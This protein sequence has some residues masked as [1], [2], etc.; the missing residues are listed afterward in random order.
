MGPITPALVPL[1]SGGFQAPGVEDFKLPPIFG[2][3]SWLQ[4][5]DKPMFQAIISVIL[6]LAFWVWVSSKRNMVPGKAQFIGEYAYSFVRNSSARDVIGHDF[7]K[8]VPYLV[9]LFSF[10]LVNNL[11][12]IFPLLLFPTASHVGWAYG[13]AALSWVI[14]NV[15]GII[16]HGP[17]GYLKLTVMPAGV[18]VWMYPLVIPIEFLSNIIV[19]PITLSLRLFANMFAGHLLVL[20]FILGGE[21][22]ILHTDSIFNSVV[23]GVSLLFSLAIFLLE[24]VVQALQAYIFTILTAQYISSSVAEAH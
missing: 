24:L 4:W 2:N 13:L 15:V 16:K 1:D 11:F 10:V 17:L 6:I 23:G 22:L 5:L 18:P 3:V 9:A 8:Y 20:V 21:Y 12:G 14:Y 19:R 7:K